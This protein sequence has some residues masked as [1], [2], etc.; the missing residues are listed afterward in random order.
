MTAE[1]GSTTPTWAEVIRRA[2]RAAMLELNTGLPARVVEYDPDTQSAT[3]QPLFKRAFLDQDE[4]ENVVKAPSIQS[5]PVI[6]PGGGGWCIRWRLAPGDVVFLQFSQRSMDKLKQAPSGQEVDPV[7]SR[8]HDLSDAVALATFR[9]PQGALPDPGEDLVL[10]REDGSS[11]IRLKPDGVIELGADGPARGVVRIDDETL[12]DNG[13]DSAFVQWM[14]AVDAGFTALAALTAPPLSPV[15]AAG[16]AYVSAS[17][18][19]PP[20]TVTGKASTA[21]EEVRSK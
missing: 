1:Q 13:T 16:A 14:A 8:H 3:V 4:N 9:T 7:E 18:G 21:S 17:G 15:G 20:S 19:G 10:G 11:E 5:V 2:I 6:F 12:V